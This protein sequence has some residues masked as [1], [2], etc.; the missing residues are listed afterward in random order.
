VIQKLAAEVT[1]NVARIAATIL[2]VMLAVF[3]I[4]IF[5]TR[6]TARAFYLRD[7]DHCR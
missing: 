3:S 6:W 1:T 4:D 5:L 2:T 7:G